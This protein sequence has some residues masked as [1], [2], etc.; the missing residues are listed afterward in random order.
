MVESA[1]YERRLTR[2]GVKVLSITQPTG[3]DL[4]GEMLRRVISLSDEYQN[5]ENGKHTLRAMKENARQGC[6]NGARPRFGYRL[7]VDEAEAVT[8]R[9]VFEFHLT[10]EHGR[11]LG[12]LGVART[13]NAHTLTYRGKPWYKSGVEV[14]LTNRAY[15]GEGG[16]TS[17]FHPGH[18]GASPP[19]FYPLAS[20]PGVGEPPHLR[21]GD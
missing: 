6:F 12:L 4:S 15:I 14:V 18:K 7:T 10:G 11:E 17:L 13:L 5:R 21:A 16:A 1:V 9:K 19:S 8:V 3:D 2:A 20:S